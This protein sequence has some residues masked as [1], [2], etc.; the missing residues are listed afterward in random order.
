MPCCHQRPFEDLSTSSTTLTGQQLSAIYLGQTWIDRTVA[1]RICCQRGQRLATVKSSEEQRLAVN[2]IGTMMRSSS[3]NTSGA[4]T[5]IV[6]TGGAVELP[7]RVKTS[8]GRGNESSKIDAMMWKDPH[9]R[10]LAYTNFNGQ[11]TT[12]IAKSNETGVRCVM[13]ESTLNYTW[14]LHDCKAFHKQDIAVLCETRRGECLAQ[15]AL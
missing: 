11:T 15:F 6:W 5:M 10:S 13:L 4:A 3:V 2:A 12:T 9:N 8:T 1:V 7:V 14:A